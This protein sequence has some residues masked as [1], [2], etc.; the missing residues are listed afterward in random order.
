MTIIAA[1]IAL[2][3]L[4]FVHEL[5]HFIA[6]KK[7]GVGVE[8]FS[9]GFGPKILG[10]KIGETEYLISAIPL[11][12][13]VKMVGEDPKE[14]SA[15]KENSFNFQPLWKKF[16]IVFAGPAFNIL[17]AVFLFILIYSFTGVTVISNQVGHVVQDYP[18]AKAGLMKGDIITSIDNHKIKTWF[19]ITQAI[20][21]NPAKDLKFNI[22]RDSKETVIFIRPQ[23]GKVK[24]VFQ[25]EIEVGLIG[26]GPAEPLKKHDPFLIIYSGFKK[27]WDIITLTL[28]AIVKLIQRVL[29]AN[30]IGGP[31]MIFQIVGEQVKI[32]IFNENLYSFLA[33]LSINLGILNLL[34][35][36]ILDGGHIMFFIIEAIRR[37]PISISKKEIAQQVGLF[38]LISLML[39]AF[40]NDLLR[41]FRK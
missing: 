17:F 36:P 5:G 33:I 40:Y 9:L 20:H 25:E 3:V 2:G 15:V 26:I 18:A 30:T 14:E 12:G 6:A 32:G 19:D 31:I 34:P 29:P 13:Y 22:I 7:S 11:G 16:I 1:V 4:I 35:I 27:T 39:L 8:K 21:K 28:L 24:N 10:K 37:K 38:L 23:L 41:V